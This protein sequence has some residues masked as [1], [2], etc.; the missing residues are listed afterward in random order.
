MSELADHFDSPERQ[1]HA[2]RLGMWVFLG[3]ELLLFAGLFTLYGAYRTKFPAE[4]AEGVR[5]STKLLGSLNTAILLVSSSFA[6]LAVEQLRRARRG[7][8]LGLLLATQACGVVFLVLKFIEYSKHFALG[9]YPGGQGRFFAAH[10]SAHF[11]PFWT[12]YFLTTG[13]HAL[14]VAVGILVLAFTTL[15][16]GR[17]SF[18]P[19]FIHP[20]HNATLYWHLVDLIWIF[21]WPLYYLA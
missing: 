11:E 18:G 12:L 5:H 14:H 19:K 15:A 2:A 20:V 13:L 16:L 17:G 3:S 10:A 7:R 1:A 8:A 4:F 21:V 6:A 9:I